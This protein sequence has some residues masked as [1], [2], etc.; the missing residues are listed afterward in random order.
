M[1]P[2]NFLAP[3]QSRDSRVFS[4][5]KSCKNQVEEV[6]S[7]DFKWWITKV[8]S[9]GKRLN[10][11]NTDCRTLNFSSVDRQNANVSCPLYIAS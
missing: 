1:E 8:G 5:A 11:I 7:D 4:E 3:V 10:M 2:R 9:A 6:G